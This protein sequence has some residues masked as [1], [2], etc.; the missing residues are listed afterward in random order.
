MNNKNHVLYLIQSSAYNCVSI[1]A[2]GSVFQSFMLESGIGEQQVALY[3]SVMQVLQT[4]VM[5]AISVLV[6]RIKNVIYSVAFSLLA[7]V[8]LFVSMLFV[9]IRQCPNR[10]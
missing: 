7:F 2:L 9:S 3:V 8:P 6:E 4:L 10:L 5:L 1:L